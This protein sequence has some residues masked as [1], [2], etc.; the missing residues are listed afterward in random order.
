MSEGGRRIEN[1]EEWRHS[2]QYIFSTEILPR[3]IV[4]NFWPRVLIA[5]KHKEELR[6]LGVKSE[7][8][9]KY[10]GF[11]DLDDHLSDMLYAKYKA[12]LPRILPHLENLLGSTEKQLVE[13]SLLSVRSIR[14]QM[15]ILHS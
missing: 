11:P 7:E 9:L 3:I 8:I 14:M 10:V 6:A 15:S 12:A 13:V 4:D 2:Q 1:E 5:N